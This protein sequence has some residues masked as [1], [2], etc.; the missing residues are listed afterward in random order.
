MV[1]YSL[2][3]TSPLFLRCKGRYIFNTTK[4][5]D[6]FFFKKHRFFKKKTIFHPLLS[7]FTLVFRLFADLI[8]I[9]TLF[10]ILNV[11]RVK[12]FKTGVVFLIFHQK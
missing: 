8:K 7:V 12:R 10:F 11:R 3:I 9:P 5:N 1:L 2:V 6:G 4:E